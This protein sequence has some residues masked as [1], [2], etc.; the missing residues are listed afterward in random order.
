MKKRRFLS[1][2]LAF[3]IIFSTYFMDMPSVYAKESDD[4]EISKDVT[5]EVTT[6]EV[7]FPLTEE[8]SDDEINRMLLAYFLWFVIVSIAF[9]FGHR[10]LVCKIKESEDDSGIRRNK[11]Q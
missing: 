8:L 10:P 1:L 7:P 5:G 3:V 11:K 6:E 9:A 2:F 4:S